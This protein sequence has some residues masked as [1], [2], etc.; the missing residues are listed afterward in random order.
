[1]TW[2]TKLFRFHQY[3]WQKL[4]SSVRM[5]LAP[6][7]VY[8]RSRSRGTKLLLSVALIL[9][10]EN[11]FAPSNVYNVHILLRVSNNYEK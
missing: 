4:I 2:T 9:T 8:S 11:L 1:M 7:I 3:E 6:S 10:K 5:S